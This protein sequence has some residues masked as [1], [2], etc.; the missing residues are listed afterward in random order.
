ME[1]P[2]GFR[3]IE[4]GKAVSKHVVSHRADAMLANLVARK[5]SGVKNHTPGISLHEHRL[6]LPPFIQ[7]RELEPRI[8]ISCPESLG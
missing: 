4:V 5:Q 3:D 8:A 1:F 2:P 7:L 6:D